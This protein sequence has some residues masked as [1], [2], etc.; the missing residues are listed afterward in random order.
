MASER[1][2]KVEEFV[3]ITGSSK[4]TAESLLA[5]CN[6]NLEMAI[7]MHMEGVQIEDN[8]SSSS[9]SNGTQPGTSSSSA[10]AAHIDDPDDDG[11]NFKNFK[12]LQNS[13]FSVSDEVRAP[14]PQKQEV[15]IQPGF[16]GYS[17]NRSSNMLRGQRVRSVFDGFRNFSN[18]ASKSRIEIGKKKIIKWKYS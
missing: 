12:K 10:A 4:Q 7:N 6:D 17:I 11:E 9:A 8:N 14:I 5:A 13:L 18:E 16:E 2:Q 15:L 3:A 1:E